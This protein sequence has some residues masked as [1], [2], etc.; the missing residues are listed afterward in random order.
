[1]KTEAALCAQAIRKELKQAFPG[2]KFSVTSDNFSMGN[3]VDVSWTDGPTS[4]HVQQIVN[5]YQYGHFDGMT[6]SYEHS[7]SRTD[8]PQAKFIMTKREMSDATRDLLVKE[9][10]E[11]FC[12][13]GQITDLK[14]F[15]KDADCWNDQLIYR[16]FVQRD[17]GVGFDE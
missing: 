11:K 10:N 3:S 6:D 13:T 5:K 4:E 8:I 2:I 7:N 9:H 12:E 14:A 17:I 1:M 15:N 16:E